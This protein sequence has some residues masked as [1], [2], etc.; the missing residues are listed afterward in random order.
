MVNYNGKTCLYN[1]GPAKTLFA[2]TVTVIGRLNPLRQVLLVDF[3]ID[4]GEWATRRTRRALIRCSAVWHTTEDRK[5][6]RPNWLR[7]SHR[8]GLLRQWRS[9]STGGLRLMCIP[10]PYG[11]KGS[12]SECLCI[13]GGIGGSDNK[14]IGFLR[15]PVRFAS[16]TGTSRP[17][18]ADYA[19]AA[20]Q[21]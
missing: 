9:A 21:Q 10:K 5:T 19:T 1:P 4:P 12:S 15:L 3:Q 11:G 17:G 6:G 2:A 14:V 8:I 16:E 7:S 13:Y 18:P 20:G